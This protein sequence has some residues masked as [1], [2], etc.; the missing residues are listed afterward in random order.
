[1]VSGVCPSAC[2]SK[3]KNDAV[4]QH[5]R[6]DFAYV[7]DAEIQAF[8]H[9]NASTRPHSTSACAPRGELP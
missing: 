1:M 9:T 5:G 2:A 4:P 8:V 6:R 7:I 3:F